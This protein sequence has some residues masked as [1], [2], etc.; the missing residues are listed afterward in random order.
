MAVTRTLANDARKK[1]ANGEVTLASLK[2]MFFT[3]S[4]TFDASSPAL[5]GYTADKVTGDGLDANG[6]ALANAAITVTSTNQATL[7]ADDIDVT[8]TASKTFRSAAIFDDADAND[9]ILLWLQNDADATGTTAVKVLWN[10]SGIIV[11]N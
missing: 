9:D 3:S 6:E 8:V 10:A 5:S 7:D 2:V 11:W 4:A 1:F